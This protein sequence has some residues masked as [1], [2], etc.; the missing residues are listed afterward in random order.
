MM[1]GFTKRNASTQV[2][3]WCPLAATSLTIPQITTK[4]GRKI[5]LTAK[6]LA[7]MPFNKET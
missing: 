4:Y 3:Q 2:S 1:A 7:D 6:R 5:M